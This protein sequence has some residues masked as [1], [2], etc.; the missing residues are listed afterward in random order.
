MNWVARTRGALIG[1]WAGAPVRGLA[2]ARGA[3]EVTRRLAVVRVVAVVKVARAAVVVEAPMRLRTPPGC[4]IGQ[5]CNTNT[6]VG[7]VTVAQ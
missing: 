3:P 4:F 1:V 6:D 2:V 5:P 7:G